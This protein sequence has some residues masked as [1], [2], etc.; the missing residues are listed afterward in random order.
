MTEQMVPEGSEHAA[1]VARRLRWALPLL[2]VS[3]LVLAAVLV[4]S[5]WRMQRWELAPGEAQQVAPR[6]QFE[7]KNGAA[8][9]TR[10]GTKNKIRFVTAFG[11]QVSALD[12]FV[13]W[14]DPEVN[15]DTY[16]RRF[17]Q[18]TPSGDRQVAFQAM[19]GAKQV[20]EYVAMHRLGYDA[21]FVEGPIVVED[22]VCEQ[23]PD[24]AS[25]CKVLRI[26]DTVTKFDG[27]AVEHVAD[28][29]PLMKGRV[30]GDT[31]SLSVRPAGSSRDVTRTVKLIASPDDKTRVI[32]GFIPADTRSVE[33]PF[34]VN[35]DTTD[36]GGPSAGLAF[37]LA[38]LDELS[39]G[40]L[41]GTTPVA[42]TGTIDEKGEVG[43][44]GALT[45][46]AIAVRDAG[47]KVFLV[48]AGQSDAEI[49]AARN[50]AGSGVRIITVATLDDALAALRQL[51]GDPL[52]S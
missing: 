39:P 11:G 18:R 40:E 49:A 21:R 35:I 6:M 31:V 52:P 25:A 24:P 1:S 15:I 17:G 9:P 5:A 41:L 12:S 3:W 8:A 43:A 26:G 29:A 42:A 16:E 50:A 47:A 36:I 14:L 32:I 10:Y 13:G 20:A 33:L 2:T 37:T 51:G 7:G 28:L 30:A 45:Q 19:F 27:T 22:V 4:A 44:I 23:T 46:K 48:P 34:D 38:L